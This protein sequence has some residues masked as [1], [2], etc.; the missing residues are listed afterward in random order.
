MARRSPINQCHSCYSCRKEKK[1]EDGRGE[2]CDLTM[3]KNKSIF[4]NIN[5]Q[6]HIAPLAVFRIVFGLMMFAA[7]V[8][9]W[10]NGW[11]KSL[12]I[13]PDFYFPYLG[14]E[15]VKPL[16]DPGMYVAFALM[17]ISALM[18]AFGFFFRFLM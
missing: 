10:S 6:V 18:I 9:F 7:I 3:T 17:A 5:K 15:W 4:L 13:D 1:R 8:R 11:I 12:Y 16:G 2:T 14:F